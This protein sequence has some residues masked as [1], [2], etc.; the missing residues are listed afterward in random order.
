MTKET[1]YE[2]VVKVIRQQR[3]E[4]DLPVTPEMSLR[5]DLGVDS[6]ELMEFVIA[7]EDEFNINI[8][9]EDVDQMVRMSDLL[10]YLD[11]KVNK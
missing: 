11:K 4:D 5:D 10:T 6:I 2:T 8:P 9:D 1:I 7:L 3:H